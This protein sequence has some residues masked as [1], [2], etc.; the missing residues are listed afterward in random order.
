MGAE[1]FIHARNQRLN[2]LTYYSRYFNMVEVNSTYYT[3]CFW[4][5]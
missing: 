1:F 3:Y 5:L 2:W 4:E